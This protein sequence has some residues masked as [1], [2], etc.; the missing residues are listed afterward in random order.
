MRMVEDRANAEREGLHSKTPWKANCFQI[1]AADGSKVAHTGMGQLPPH[2][3]H[4][5]RANAEFIV[6]AVNAYSAV[7]PGVL[8]A[9]AHPN[10][11]ERLRTMAGFLPEQASIFHEAAKFIEHLSIKLAETRALVEKLQTLARAVC[12]AD[13]KYELNDAIADLAEAITTAFSSTKDT[14]P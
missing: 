2:R 9:K 13:N 1:V 14:Q 11:V 6:E 4:E 10:L 8:A 3:S 7:S 12:S 5:A